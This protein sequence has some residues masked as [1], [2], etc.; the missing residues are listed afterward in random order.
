MQESGRDV[1]SGSQRIDLVGRKL[2]LMV[3]RRN[4][5]GM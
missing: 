5:V 2:R 3:D 1:K 4:K